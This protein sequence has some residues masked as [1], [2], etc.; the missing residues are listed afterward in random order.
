[1]DR[2]ANLVVITE[3]WLRDNGMDKIWMDACKLNKNG[4]K[5]QVQNRGEGRG[6]VIELVYRDNITVKMSMEADIPCLNL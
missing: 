4:C 2:K 6:G 3:T 1:M 5:L